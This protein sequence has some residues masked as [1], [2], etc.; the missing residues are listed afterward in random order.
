MNRIPPVL[1]V[2]VIICC[3]VELLIEVAIFAGIPAARQLTF[4]FGAFWSDLVW[5]A[6]PI[7]P[8]QNI[9]MFVTYGFLHSGLIH[10]GMNM[11]SLI[12]LAPQLGM[13][14]DGRRLL[15]IY[16]V[17]QLAAAGLFAYMTPA[18]GPMIGASGAVFGLA[19]ALIGF[20]A[21]RSQQRGLPMGPLMRSA[22]LILLLNLGLTVMVPSIAWEAHLGGAL[23]GLAM[24]LLF[25]G[26]S[27][28]R[29]R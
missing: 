21:R 4:A 11:L 24:G 5:G 10:L 16:A 1:L 13:I 6:H 23:A 27:R 25:A 17:S 8:G 3:V 26:P 29:F 18:A 20:A 15:A 9:L 7:Y 2:I 14:F 12:A 19:G 22:G 28:R